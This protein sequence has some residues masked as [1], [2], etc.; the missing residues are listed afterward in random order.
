MSIRAGKLV[1]L[2]CCGGLMLQAGGCAV[3]IGQII[4]QQVFSGVLSVL[5]SSILTGV[6][7]GGGT[8]N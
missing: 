7:G 2:A 1:A 3:A 6:T 5:L 8:T 4:A